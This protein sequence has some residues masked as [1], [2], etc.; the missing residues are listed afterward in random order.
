MLIFES[1]DSL[2]P[3]GLYPTRL[4]YPWNSPGKNTGAGCHS[5]LQWIFLTQG[6]NPSLLH[7]RQ[8]LYLLGHQGSYFIHSIND[9]Y[10]SIPISHFIPPLSVPPSYPHVYSF[11]LCVCVSVSDLQIGSLY[12]IFLDSHIRINIPCLF[13]SF[14]LSPL[15]DRV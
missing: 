7:Y 12:T 11:V 3:H 10:R 2:Q 14:W 1:L 6:S 15:C 5:L 4:L 8:I 13:F 9:A